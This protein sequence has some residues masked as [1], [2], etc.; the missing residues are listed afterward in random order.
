M[1]LLGCVTLLSACGGHSN[2][3]RSN[4][5]SVQQVTL[6]KPAFDMDTA[7]MYV[8]EQVR[9][10]ARIPASKAHQQCANYLEKILTN[11]ADQV[12][13]QPFT[14]KLWDGSTARGVNVIGS[15]NPTAERR[16]VLAAHWDSRATADRDLNADNHRK[17][18][19]GAN[20]G[21]SGVGVLLEVARQLSLNKTDVGVDIILFDLEDQGTPEYVNQDNMNSWCLGAQYWAANL[22]RPGYKAN[23]GIL[24]DMVGCYNPCFTKEA[25]SQRLAPD[26]QNNVWQR[27]QE[28]GFSYCFKNTLTS[29]VL[30]DHYFVNTIAGIPMIDLIQYDPTTPSHFFPQW[31]TMEDD[32]QHVD[33]QTL[34]IVGQV[35]LSL[36][37]S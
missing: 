6:T 33:K 24:L 32:L 2:K 8:A 28:L 36:I 31:H 13:T 16:I 3:A 37:Y 4:S 15:F 25:T 19:L 12:I 27:A 26:I 14:S 1:V 7:F 34:Q 5:T 17:P 21:A 35:L 9:F 11:Y 22:H 20:D 23:Y 18:L 10:G 30:D 29:G